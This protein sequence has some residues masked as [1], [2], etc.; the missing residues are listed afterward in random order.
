MRATFYAVA[1]GSWFRFFYRFRRSPFYVLVLLFF[2]WL[3][4]M[5]PVFYL[6][7]LLG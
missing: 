4:N 3:L 6:G 1:G 7:C 5:I 2:L